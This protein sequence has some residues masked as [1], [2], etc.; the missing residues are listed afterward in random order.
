MQRTVVVAKAPQ[1]IYEFLGVSRM[2]QSHPLES[3]VA[4]AIAVR[5]L[6]FSVNPASPIHW[7]PDFRA[8]FAFSL[9][10]IGEA[11]LLLPAIVEIR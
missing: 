7:S 3:N 10:R 2:D 4:D 11:T 9:G 8:S 6:R 1:L 5:F